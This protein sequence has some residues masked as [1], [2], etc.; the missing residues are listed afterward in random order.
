MRAKTYIWVLSELLLRLA[1]FYGSRS[2]GEYHTINYSLD[3]GLVQAVQMN[4]RILRVQ[5]VFIELC[6]LL[7]R[8]LYLVKRRNQGEFRLR[9]S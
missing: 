8:L 4:Y 6:Q 7:C 2:V 5:P 9:L 1:R 3:N